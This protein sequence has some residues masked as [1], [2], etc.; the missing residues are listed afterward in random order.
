M[1]ARTSTPT[2][3][4]QIRTLFNIGAIGSMTDGALLEHFSLGGEVAEPAFA[5]LVERHGPMVM[6]VCR[7]ML[8]DVHL[9]EDA[10]Q[11]HFCC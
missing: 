10:F 7:N 1:A 11:V 4:R 5:T 2:M 6:R 3:D 8:N 9:A